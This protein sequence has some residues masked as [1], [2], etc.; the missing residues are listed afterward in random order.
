MLPF[1]SSSA[2]CVLVR[3]ESAM[4]VHVQFLCAL[5]TNGPA[6]ATTTFFASCAWHHSFRTEVRGLAPGK[7]FLGKTL[8]EVWPE[9]IEP[10]TS[11][12]RK[13]MATGEPSSTTH[14]PVQIKR[15]SDGPL[16]DLYV[17]IMHVPLPPDASGRPRVL[18]ITVDT[19]RQI[20]AQEDLERAV[21]ERTNSLR[22]A[23]QE[24]ELNTKQLRAL[25]GEL[26]MTEQRERKHLAK[27]LHDDRSRIT[28]W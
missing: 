19:T 11:L 7:E 25:A 9:N 24:L 18:E 16:E 2:R 26:T 8:A 17:N 13:V 14:G 22:K 5:L 21:A 27:V 15:S 20:R 6:S 12:I 4:I 10:F 1:L 3:H 28:Q 23:N